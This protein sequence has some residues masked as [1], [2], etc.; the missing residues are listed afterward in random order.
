MSVGCN[1]DGSGEVS[2]SA[3]GAGVVTGAAGVEVGA[4]GGADAVSGEGTPTCG[5]PAAF[6]ASAT[7]VVGVGVVGVSSGSCVV[8]GGIICIF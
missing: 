5:L 4:T 2:L 6:D 7:G 1:A 3:V 8:F